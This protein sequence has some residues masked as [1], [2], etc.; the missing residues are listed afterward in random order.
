MGASEQRWLGLP[1]QEEVKEKLAIKSLYW[2][3]P[4][5]FTYVPG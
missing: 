4:M 3:V 5:S 2:A 1:S